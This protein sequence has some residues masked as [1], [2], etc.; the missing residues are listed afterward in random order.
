MSDLDDM[1]ERDH[2]VISHKIDVFAAALKAH[3]IKEGSLIAHQAVRPTSKN[4][5]QNHIASLANRGLLMDLVAM[6][7]TAWAAD[8]PMK[9]GNPAG[10]DNEIETIVKQFTGMDNPPRRRAH[11]RALHALFYKFGGPIAPDVIADV[12]SHEAAWDV[13]LKHMVLH[14][15]D[16][17]D[18][19]YW[20]HER[21]VLQRLAKQVAGC[22]E[23]T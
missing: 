7:I 9:T 19:S 17:A 22:L 2:A 11:R 21:D 14:A 6:L 5:I 4:H 18:M 16:E 20:Q 23:P 12:A 15:R 1:N 10:F 8:W 13:A 3:L